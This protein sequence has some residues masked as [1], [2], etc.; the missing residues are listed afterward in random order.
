[1]TIDVI[2]ENTTVQ[3]ATE[4]TKYAGVVDANFKE[5][6]PTTNH[7]TD[8]TLDVSKFSAS[9]HAHTWIRFDGLSNISSSAV[10]SAATLYLYQSIAN[11]TYSIDLRRLLRAATE[12]GITW[13]KYDGTNDWTTAGGLGAA[14]DRVSTPESSTSL[15]ATT[16]VYYALDCTSLVQDIIDGTIASDEG[17]HLERADSGEDSNFKAFVSNEGSDGTRPELVVTY[18]IPSA[19]A[20]ITGTITATVDEDDVVTG[21]KTIIITLTGD[22]WKAAGTG[23]IGST[24]DTQAIIDGLDSAQVEATGWNAEVRDKEVTTAVVR[25]SSTICTITLTASA[26]YDITAQETIT[27]TVPIAGLVTGAGAIT[28]T[29]TFTVD[30]VAAATVVDVNTNEIIDDAETGNT[31]TVSGFV[32]DIS[33]VKLKSGT[34]ETTVLNLSGTGD[35]YT[36]D[37]VDVAGFTSD[38]VGAPLTSANNIA[39]VEATDGVDTAVLT[40]SSVAKAGWE[41]VEIASA[42][43]TTGSIF[44]NFVGTI[45]DESLIYYAT[46]DNTS[47]DATGIVTTDSAVDIT[48]QFWDTSDD[49][50][51]QLTLLIEEVARRALND[52]KVDFLLDQG[53]TKANISDMELAWLQS[54]G[55]TSNNI[56]G[57]WLEYLAGVGFTTGTLVDRKKAWLVSKSHNKGDINTSFKDFW[58]NGTI[59]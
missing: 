53:I 12:A 3:N 56:N 14:S 10:V 47:V 15:I 38:T 37:N 17:F 59:P 21:G 13:N 5:S 39:Q 44:E 43:K 32:S 58:E 29:P 4:D 57:A 51:K 25:T 24:A 41:R 31:L 52:A 1:M 27:V 2:T 49:T 19:T 33:T 42:V 40:V 6:A 20:A 23:P 28:S 34:A 48:M 16:G 36:F 8:A 18:T 35:N 30:T 26:A 54:L 55:A 11:A 9:N 22:T 50:W 46:A 7:G 45:V